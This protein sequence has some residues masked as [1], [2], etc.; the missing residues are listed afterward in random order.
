MFEFSLPQLYL[1]VLGDS[2]TAATV[3]PNMLDVD[4]FVCYTEAPNV[5]LCFKSLPERD[6]E[7]GDLI[8]L[9]RFGEI[10]VRYSF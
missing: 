2:C 10:Q 1:Q 8:V 9:R 5:C 4:I 3:R 7:Q 6:T